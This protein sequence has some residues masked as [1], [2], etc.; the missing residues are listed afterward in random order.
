[1]RAGGVC[2]MELKA[3]QVELSTISDAMQK[4][5]GGG[6]AASDMDGVNAGHYFSDTAR[7]QRINLLLHLIHYADLLLLSSAQGS[8]KTTLLANFVERMGDDWQIHQ[9]QGAALAQEMSLSNRL[10]DIF[11]TAGDG[12]AERVEHLIK[13][14]PR[15]RRLSKPI[16]LI[17]D[18][19]EKL[20]L[21]SMQLLDKIL[22]A[23]D[24]YGKPVHLILSGRPGLDDTLA[25]PELAGLQD[26]VAHRLDVP[27]LS[28]AHT[29]ELIQDHLDESHSADKTLFNAATIKRI[30]RCS[31]GYPGQILSEIHDVLNASKAQQKADKPVSHA[32]G[33][34]PVVGVFGEGRDGFI[35]TLYSR[36]LIFGA[37][38][39]GAALAVI[40]VLRL[41]GDA[42]LVPVSADVAPLVEIPAVVIV[43]PDPTTQSETLSLVE[44][45]LNPSTPL[46]GAP[47]S[48]HP[49]SALP[50][51]TAETVTPESA[52][53][54][55]GA[56][57][58]SLITIPAPEV[59]AEST[60]EVEVAEPVTTPPVPGSIEKSI[61]VVSAQPEIPP[62][63]VGEAPPLPEQPPA[64]PIE[65]VIPQGSV[66][67]PLA[68]QGHV[69][70]E[71]VA[72][73]TVSPPIKRDDWLL[74]QDPNH[75][76]LQ[77][78]AANNEVGV[79]KFIEDNDLTDVAA[80]FF[81][82]RD[83]NPW[84]AVTYGTY[85]SRSEANAAVLPS[86]LRSIKPWP[87]T[88]GGIHNAM[89]TA[90]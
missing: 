9:L 61:E 22:A 38:A 26:R 8:G 90:R 41:G 25:L 81:S 4:H 52:D 45:L 84:Y 36:P 51:P 1:M 17:I 13:H 57:L 68:P 50:T 27:P 47:D 40:G 72:A 46:V 19:A 67:S 18:D 82:Q 59:V 80:Y 73:T 54:P 86:A 83:G 58:T 42:E 49:N 24:N 20:A 77:L 62:V 88:F 21:A 12:H 28:E 79:V 48:L 11:G 14:M 89:R 16:I 70:G 35:K 66:L 75:F 74:Q 23:G 63:V 33:V 69:E 29:S 34:L 30:F 56:E 85:S 43:E 71:H 31:K 55:V 64:E 39:L 3:D 6:D 53:V 2:K 32:E 7:E 44:A 78:M 37:I 60:V 76:T 87:R 65:V 10:A 5:Y 15:L